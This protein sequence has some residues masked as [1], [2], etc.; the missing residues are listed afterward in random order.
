MK[1]NK[2]TLMLGSILA[3]MINTSTYAS[4][5]CT[6]SPIERQGEV[7]TGESH[8]LTA[9]THY[10]YFKV[11]Y[12]NSEVTITLSGGTFSGSN[13]AELQLYTGDSWSS[14]ELETSV[15]TINSNNESMSFVSRAGD[16][17][18]KI[19]GDIQQANLNITVSGGD[20]TPPLGDFIVY[21]T[22]IQIDLPN[23]SITSK[24]QYHDDVTT[25]LT[26]GNSFTELS[27]SGSI[28]INH[29]S[30][31]LHFL[32]LENDINDSDISNLLYF[33]AKYSEKG[34][35]LTDAEASQL[36][37]AMQALAKMEDFHTTLGNSSK[38]Q[39]AYTAAIETFFT[40]NA[41]EYFE[42]QLP[43][44]LA[45][46]QA[47]SLFEDPW[48]D[49][50]YIDA[51]TFIPRLLGAASTDGNATVVRILNDNMINV[52]SVLRSFALLGNTYIHA[53]QATDDN[54]LWLVPNTLKSIARVSTIASPNAIMRINEMV[55][56]I[57]TK[58]NLSVDKEK[59]DIAVKNGFLD[60][61]GRTCD[62]ND[63]LH[64]YCLSE[65][66]ILTTTYECT[67][68]FTFRAQTGISQSILNRSCDEIKTLETEFHNLFGT[69]KNTPVSDDLND[70]LE[71][72][73][74]SSP[75]DY[76]KYASALF[77]VSTDNGGY[78]REG[79]PNRDTNQPRFFAMTCDDD[80]VGNSCEYENQIY[81]LKHELVH[82]LDGRYIKYGR[83]AH[84]DPS[85]GWTEGLA[86]YLAQGNVYQRTL[87]NIKGK[88]VPPLHNVLFMGDDFD[89]QYQWGYFGIHYLANEHPSELLLLANVQK[90]G[91]TDEYLTTL[92]GIVNRIGAGFIPYVVANSEAVAPAAA[93]IPDANSFGSCD[94]IQ[95]YASPYDYE[96]RAVSVTNTTGTPVSLFW[97]DDTKGTYLGSKNYQTLNQGDSFTASKWRTNDR[98]VLTDNNYNC[99]AVSV[100][101]EAEN[102]F[103]INPETVA[104][105][106]IEVI[107]EANTFGTCDLVNS[108]II[109]K[110]GTGKQTITNNTNY[111]VS[112]LRIN[113]I[114][115]EPIYSTKYATLSQGETFAPSTQWYENRR[116]MLADTKLDC[117]AVGVLNHE[118]NDYTITAGLVESAPEPE[119]IPD[120]NTIGSCDLVQKH[121]IESEGYPMTITNNSDTP[122]EVYRVMNETGEIGDL[123]YRTL[124]PG[125]SYIKDDPAKAW[126]GNRRVAFTTENQQCLGVAVLTE[127]LGNTFSI[128]QAL[129]DNKTDLIDSDGDG[130]PD[131]I[132]AFPN[133]PNESQ[134]TDGDGVGNNTDAFPND[135]SET[136][137]TDGDSVGDNADAFPND[138]TETHDS[139]GDGIGDNSDPY[140]NDSNNGINYCDISGEKQTHE[141]ITAVSIGDKTHQSNNENG[142]YSDFTHIS[143]S[144]TA[145]TQ[146]TLT[147]TSNNSGDSEYWYVWIDFNQ[148]GDFDDSNELIVSD[149]TSSENLTTTFSVP[150]SAEGKLRM[151]TVLT[152]RSINNACESFS[153][154]EVEDYTLNITENDAPTEPPVLSDVPNACASQSAFTGN[155]LIADEAICLSNDSRH[156]FT[157]KGVDAYQSIAIRT[158][159]GTGD[160]ALTF[161]QGSWPSDSSFDAKSDTTNTNTECIN[162]D[163]NDAY[164]G[165]LEVNGAAEGASLLVNFDTD[166]CR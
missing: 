3:T 162:I 84:N 160:L 30:A 6:A 130:V 126:Y 49:S 138:P 73:A 96:A 34:E 74:F 166:V 117:L 35:P 51:L 23:A 97:L 69:D 47:Y 27:E 7:T 9:N 121:F 107:P 82:Y 163:T 26:P 128:S 10:L 77:S 68:N 89:G 57:H 58:L 142:G 119:V 104:N 103:T 13:D 19:R 124:Q 132:D 36:S 67:D 56:E 60:I 145:G 141:W 153:Y 15:D 78:Y 143:F 98:M 21:N 16:R 61:A 41:S 72:I 161:K 92:K 150:Q 99:L 159:H 44:M 114:T 137:D 22:N 38:V 147:L 139:D 81:N 83:F 18:F 20:I 54:K 65:G 29:I 131:N 64:N 158:A 32:A 135:A 151:R 123:K 111:P 42:A 80:W 133:D 5:L 109:N 112:I 85:T 40:G 52:L 110:N 120:A 66:D 8:C 1:L 106:N 87:K 164:W 136:T 46:I 125:E 4:D 86:E 62:T 17:Y 108:H 156:T 90:G 71:I 94:L 101:T 91:D 148:D 116:V 93:A 140:P 11:P 37:I 105:A 79:N 33:I 118:N 63:A 28:D 59:I 45:L 39:I 95:Q 122:V 31:A 144:A 152:Y 115:G 50:R 25:V 53:S 55:I 155:R 146:Q 134:D 12:E 2:T 157:I 43:H 76:K 129:V 127:Q 165:Y 70:N 75:D 149:R 88:T 154:G 113:D 24:S 14:D 48:S 100:M 102:T